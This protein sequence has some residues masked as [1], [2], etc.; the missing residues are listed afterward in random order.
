MSTSQAGQ[1]AGGA[2][3]AERALRRMVESLDAG[4]SNAALDQRLSQ[5]EGTLAP[6]GGLRCRCPRCAGLL[7]RLVQHASAEPA[8]AASAFAAAALAVAA[9]PTGAASA[10]LAPAL[11]DGLCRAIVAA[12]EGASQLRAPS[13]PGA[14]PAGPMEWGPQEWALQHE[15]HP[16]VRVL[17]N[18]T[19]VVALVVFIYYVEAPGDEA[20]RAALAPRA[21]GTPGLPRALVL[22][23]LGLERSA[24]TGRAPDIDSRMDLYMT[25]AGRV[26]QAAPDEA[27]AGAVPCAVQIAARRLAVVAS[28][29]AAAAS[30]RGGG[31]GGGGGGGRGRSGGGGGAGSLS[32]GAAAVVPLSAAWSRLH[33]DSAL[34]LAREAAERCGEQGWAL[35]LQA[36]GSV[37][38]RA[39]IRRAAAAARGDA[40]GNA[41]RADYD[42][43]AL[44]VACDVLG[45]GAGVPGALAAA[46]AGSGAEV[47]RAM[48]G[49]LAWGA[50]ELAA[51]PGDGSGFA[52]ACGGAA[53]AT[54][55]RALEKLT[56]DEV[57]GGAP[58]AT[59]SVFAVPGSAAACVA[60]L[61]AF[62]GHAAVAAAV[63]ALEAG[64]VCSAD[65]HVT[66][67]VLTA[68]AVAVT[69]YHAAA[70]PGMAK[71]WVAS[72]ARLG[73]EGHLR[74]ARRLGQSCADCLVSFVRNIDAGLAAMQRAAASPHPTAASHAAA[75]V[76]GSAAVAS[77]T[78][79]QAASSGRA[80]PGAA[81][82]GE[83]PRTRNE[84]IACQQQPEQPQLPQQQGQ[85]QG[86]QQ[87]QLQQQ[88]LQPQQQPSPTRV[89]TCATCGR[90]AAE[91]GVPKLLVCGACRCVRYCPSGPCAAAGW[92]Q[93][94]REQCAALWAQRC[95]AKAAAAAA[96]AAASGESGG[97]G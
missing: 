61:R 93:G 91:A 67:Y 8:T 43:S 97:R 34:A 60:A 23:V 52:I 86:Q 31:R 29:E 89:H 30:P 72:L 71:A 41:L 40:D 12:A 15:R 51:G 81:G 53:V 84:P 59:A 27:A 18:L 44:L 94:H 1:Q 66:D 79:P 56:R 24:A 45:R 42:R 96:T 90:T 32:A 4:A 88:Q 9:R 21:A 50:H 36:P 10:L 5:L 17:H 78:A 65:V 11:I 73:A 47:A 70:G 48:V 37:V 39:A 64:T 58:G 33:G 82:A 28:A 20:R 85:Q 63:A 2:L 25:A 77:G 92:A 83:Q 35:L 7:A 14:A 55:M 95:A 76:G 16:C 26:V 57:E 49:L 13:R 3:E 6:D 38:L 62:E 75:G 87:L 69:A 19:S 46:A 22:G 54:A 80:A 74:L 68:A